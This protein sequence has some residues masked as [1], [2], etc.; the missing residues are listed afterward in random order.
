MAQG[1]TVDSTAFKVAAV[2]IGGLVTRGCHRRGHRERLNTAVLMVVGSSFVLLGCAVVLLHADTF[3]DHAIEG[4]SSWPPAVAA[5]TRWRWCS[6]L[7]TGHRGVH[8]AALNAHGVLSSKLSMVLYRRISKCL[9]LF[10]CTCACGCRHQRSAGCENLQTIVSKWLN[11][12][13]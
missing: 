6:W 13:L 10:W 2:L 7:V 8:V 12:F 1:G 9:N 3:K 5:A 11:S 4:A